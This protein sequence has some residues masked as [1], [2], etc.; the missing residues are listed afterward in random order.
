[1]ENEYQLSESELKELEKS[2]QKNAVVKK[3][4]ELIELIQANPAINAYIALS[5]THNN[6]CKEVM[7]ND[8]K[9]FNTDPEFAKTFDGYLKWKDKLISDVDAM[10]IL[11]NKLLPQEEVIASKKIKGSS[12]QLH[13]PKPILNGNRN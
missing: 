12:N 8:V 7:E 6:I 10:N 11:K 5:V 2:A 13:I 9:L 4:L 3:A 1:M